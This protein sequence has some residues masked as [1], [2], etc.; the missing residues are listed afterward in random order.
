MKQITREQC[1]L[2][3]KQARVKPRLARELRFVPEDVSDWANRE[4]LAITTRSGAEGVLL[5]QLDDFYL[6]PFRLTTKLADKQSGRARPVVCDFCYTW[7][8]GGKTASITCTDQEDDSRSVNFLCCGDLEC[9]LNVRG[10]TAAATLSR[11]QLH[12]DISIERRIER[13]RAKLQSLAKTTH[14]FPY[15]L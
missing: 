3:I 13:L 2:L 4:L 7:Q 12:E 5:M 6:L 15:T 9:S 10:L 14:C 1:T 8:R 11:A